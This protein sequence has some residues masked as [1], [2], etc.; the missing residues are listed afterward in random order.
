MANTYK[1]KNKEF[2]LTSDGS[3]VSPKIN[4]LVKFTLHNGVDELIA[5]DDM[6]DIQVGDFDVIAN[7]MM[8]A[9]VLAAANA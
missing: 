8:E 3:E 7:G 2:I 4:L 6:E 1:V 5:F 9:A